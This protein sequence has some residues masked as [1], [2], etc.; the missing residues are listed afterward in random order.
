MELPSG[1]VTFLFTDLED[2]TRLWEEHPEVMAGALARHD[3]ILEDEVA[4]HG[5]MVF[6]R[7]GDG[8]AAAFGSARDAVTA[9]VA[10]QQA[11][12]VER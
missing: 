9:A 12:A 3:A 2:S 6:S 11:L 4:A 5:G 7:M 8:I 10:A 1:T